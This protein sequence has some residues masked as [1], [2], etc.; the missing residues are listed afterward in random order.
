MRMTRLAACVAILVCVAATT[1]FGSNWTGGNGNWNLGGNWDAGVPDGTAAYIGNGST[2]TLNSGVPSITTLDVAW[3]STLNIQPGAGLTASGNGNVAGG[4]NDFGTV[5]QT[6]GVV[7]LE[8]NLTIGG[9]ADDI[10]SW[11]MTTDATLAVGADLVVGA[12]GQGTFDLGGNSSLTVAGNI[13]IATAGGG[14]SSMTVSGGATLGQV[15]GGGDPAILADVSVNGTG[16]FLVDGS[17]PTINVAS[18][19]QTSGASLNVDLDDTGISA[20]NIDGSAVLNGAL[21]VTVAG[22]TPNGIYN[23]IVAGGGRTGS[24]SSKSLPAGVKLRYEEVGAD[25]VVRL[26]VGVEPPAVELGIIDSFDEGPQYLN[27]HG[28]GVSDIYI[29]T[30][31]MGD[32]RRIYCRNAHTSPDSILDINGHTSSAP[33]EVLASGPSAALR[34]IGW[35]QSNEG[36]ADWS[37]G[38][39]LNLDVPE[40]ATI[41]VDVAEVITPWANYPQVRLFFDGGAKRAEYKLQLNAATAVPQTIVLDLLAPDWSSAPL[42]A[43]DLSDVDGIR[44]HWYDGAQTRISEIRFVD[45]NA[46]PGD[47]TIPE[48]TGLGLIGLALLAVRRRRS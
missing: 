15:A 39:P 24:F 7:L 41:E 21:N 26:Y 35:G 25:S 3:F 10:A 45:P 9:A 23:I 46:G 42:T 11:A 1:A 44:L 32:E 16:S 48:P 8:S 13:D 6:G 12:A 29:G 22:G 20:I 14:G 17:A 38:N 31:P 33:G 34:I 2:V 27:G 4:G 37:D 43:A 30:G 18:Y 36:E 28:T 47:P 19:T 5:A 40:D